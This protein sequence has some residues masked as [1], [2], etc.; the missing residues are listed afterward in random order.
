MTLILLA[1]VVSPLWLVAGQTSPLLQRY[2]LNGTDAAAVCNDG[3]SGAA[4]AAV[5]TFTYATDAA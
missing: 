4:L 5:D 1:D 2:Y 3:S